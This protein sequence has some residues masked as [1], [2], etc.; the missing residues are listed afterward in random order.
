MNLFYSN[1]QL[2]T[3]VEY[4]NR[5]NVML[6]E[7]IS[8]EDVIESMVKGASNE[9]LNGLNSVYAGIMFQYSDIDDGMFVVMWVMPE[10]YDPET[11]LDVK[12]ID[13]T[14]E[15]EKALSQLSGVLEEELD[16][17]ISTIEED[18]DPRVTHY[19]D[20]VH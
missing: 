13:I 18:E 1:K 7:P 6:E 9:L 14:K 4:I 8:K 2:D 12:G 15:V 16:R 20:K 17:F 11:N 19:S 10:Y 5:N 3:V